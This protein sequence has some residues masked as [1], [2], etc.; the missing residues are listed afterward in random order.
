VQVYGHVQGHGQLYLYKK[1]T[2]AGTVDKTV[3]L[4]MKTI[5]KKRI[6]HLPFTIPYV[7]R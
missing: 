3:K 6:A 1:N 4:K 7:G 5:P 2:G